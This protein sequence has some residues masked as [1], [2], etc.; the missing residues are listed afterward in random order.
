MGRAEAAKRELL[1]TGFREDQ[2]QL[3]ERGPGI[4]DSLL[5]DR[6]PARVSLTVAAR[7]R[8]LEAAAILHRYGAIDPEAEPESEAS[9][10]GAAESTAGEHLELMVEDLVPRRVVVEIGAARIRK[11]VVSTQRSIQ[12]EVRREELL[13]EREEPTVQIPHVRFVDLEDG[14][15]DPQPED[16]DEEQVRPLG[17][18]EEVMRVP[19]LAEQIVVSKRPYIVE[20]VLLRKRRV[21]E[22]RQVAGEVRREE[23]EVEGVGD[24]TVE[25][26]GGDVVV[27]PSQS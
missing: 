10:S 21:A 24:V 2:L 27:R 4:L 26:E 20:E 3:S 13:V 16:Q 25:S 1:L 18:D 14:L 12:V 8:G 7:G 23:L 6:Q 5:G 15:P 11:R 9:Q 22:L 19:L 17:A